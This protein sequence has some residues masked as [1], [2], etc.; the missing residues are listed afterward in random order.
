MVGVGGDI[1]EWWE[2]EETLGSCGSGRR[3]WGVVGVTGEMG[4]RWEWWMKSE[5]WAKLESS[6]CG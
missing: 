4:E 6:W 1:G 2:W 3:H 5:W